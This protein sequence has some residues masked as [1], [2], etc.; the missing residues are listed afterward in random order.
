MSRTPA[1]Y[2]LTSVRG[3]TAEDYFDYVDADGNP[4]DLTDYS[5]RLQVRTEAGQYGTTT[6]TTLLLELSTDDSTLE[7]VT[8]PGGSVP[9]RVQY[10]L[11]PSEHAMLNPSNERK[12]QYPY[13]LELFVPA[14]AEPIY[15][16]PL[17]HGRWAALGW[18]VR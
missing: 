12:E 1:S 5:A 8:P 7:I 16:I 4:V 15:V 9:N 13:A 17:V 10:A 2:N 18:E 11:E 6:D 3:T 14:G